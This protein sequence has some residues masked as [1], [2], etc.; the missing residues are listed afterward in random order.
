MLG[1]VIKKKYIG[2]CEVVLLSVQFRS[3]VMVVTT[4][5]EVYLR[6]V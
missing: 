2:F 5:R 4:I 3:G 6:D 1:N